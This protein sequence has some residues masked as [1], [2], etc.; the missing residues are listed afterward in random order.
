[1]RGPHTTLRIVRSAARWR[2]VTS[3]RRGSPRAR[4]TSPGESTPRATISRMAG[5][6]PPRAA[7]EHSLLN[8]SRS[9]MAYLLSSGTAGTLS[10][11][12]TNH[13]TRQRARMIAPVDRHLAVHQHGGD[14]G[15]ISVRLLVGGA[16]GDAR[17][18]ED[19]HVGPRAGMEDAA[20]AQPERTGR[21]ARH[22]GY[23]RLEREQP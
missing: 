18:V 17:G 23:R 22:L 21:H 6:P 13:T 10:G 4:R 3:A 15:R 5:C 19:H 2:V 8:A 14:A 1:M 12:A 7:A 20:I 11:R 16:I 9:N